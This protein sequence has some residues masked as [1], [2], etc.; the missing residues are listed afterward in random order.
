MKQKD[1]M[2]KIHYID[3]LEFM[4]QIPNK[5]FDLVLTDVPYNVG[6]DYGVFKDNLSDFD[7]INWLSGVIFHLKRIS[8]EQI[9]YPSKKYF[10]E[11]WNILG[12]E[13]QQIVFTTSTSG[14]LRYGHS[15]QFSSILVSDHSVNGRAPNHYHN[16]PMPHDGFIFHENKYDH[17]GYTSMA[18]SKLLLQT[19]SRKTYTVF[20]PFMGTGTTAVACAEFGLE[21]CGCEIDEKWINV[22]NKRLCAIQ[23]DMFGIA[24]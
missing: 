13:F 24:R 23:L 14:S 2:N 15:N 11:T 7:Y 9:I 4:E 17:P 5:Y 8:R 18:L 1:F 20:D 6:K 10:L 19:Y 12:K 21:W 16:V 22:A 3:C